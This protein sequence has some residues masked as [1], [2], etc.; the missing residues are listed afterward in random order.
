MIAHYSWSLKSIKQQVHLNTFYYVLF[1]NIDSYIYHSQKSRFMGNN[2][3]VFSCRSALILTYCYSRSNDDW[4]DGRNN[5][6]N[7]ILGQCE[8][9]GQRDYL[10]RSMNFENHLLFFILLDLLPS[11]FNSGSRIRSQ[12]PSPSICMSHS[13]FSRLLFKGEEKCILK[14]FLQIIIH[15]INVWKDE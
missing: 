3:F 9:H 13:T 12:F 10:V 15:F 7:W 2:G 14:Y 5:I 4:R 8:F 11:Y 1:S 6:S